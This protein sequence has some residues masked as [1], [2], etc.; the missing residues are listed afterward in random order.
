MGSTDKGRML[1]VMFAGALAVVMA[2]SAAQGAEQKS[3]KPPQSRPV[4]ADDEAAEVLGSHLP[5]STKAE[6]T[7]AR[8]PN[9]RSA[10][11]E[12]A[13]AHL[14]E[15]ADNS[16]HVDAAQK[17]AAAVLAERP[18]DVEALVIAGQT[19]L[20]ENDLA[21]AARYYRAATL[22]DPNNATA[23]LGLGD[24]LTRLGDEPGATAAFGRYRALRGMPPLPAA[25][26]T[27]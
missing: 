8:K 27:N 9:D 2:G 5:E 17:H 25:E 19:S 10:R 12:A 23:Y 1:T 18:T 22:A 20:L 11:I 7:L 4:P 21:G 26:K 13:K 15:G 6:R 14:A 16:A 24:A 3:R